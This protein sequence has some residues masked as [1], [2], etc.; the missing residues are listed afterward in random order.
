MRA[1]YTWNGKCVPHTHSPYQTYT[2]GEISDQT[3]TEPFCVGVGLTFKIVLQT[4]PH[5][6]LELVLQTKRLATLGCGSPLGL[7]RIC[8]TPL[9]GKAECV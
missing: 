6:G 4:A 7:P 3:Q 1:I 2:K 9:R 8:T 5:N